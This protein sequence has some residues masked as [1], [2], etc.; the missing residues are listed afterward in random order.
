M[1]ILGGF[2]LFLAMERF[3]GYQRTSVFA[4]SGIILFFSTVYTIHWVLV[5]LNF[6]GINLTSNLKNLLN[7]NVKPLTNL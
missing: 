3:V 5:L 4:Y 6:S 2:Y 1:Y 7:G